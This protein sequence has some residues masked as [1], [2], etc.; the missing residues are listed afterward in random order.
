M[1]VALSRGALLLVFPLTCYKSSRCIRVYVFE[2]LLVPNISPALV[3][4]E[5][6]VCLLQAGLGNRCPFRQSVVIGCFVLRQ[7]RNGLQ[8]E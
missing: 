2:A 5:W 4:F 3:C 8:L 1:S 7:P 6:S